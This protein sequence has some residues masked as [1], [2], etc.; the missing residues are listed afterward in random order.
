MICGRTESGCVIRS[1]IFCTLPDRKVRGDISESNYLQLLI[2]LRG[3]PSQL[4]LFIG[5]LMVFNGYYCPGSHPPFGSLR[6]QKGN[7]EAGLLF[8]RTCSMRPIELHHAHAINCTRATWPCPRPARLSRRLVVEMT[9]P[10]VK[11]HVHCQTCR[12]ACCFCQMYY[13]TDGM[14]Y[15][16]FDGI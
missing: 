4:I 10:P 11:L 9:R 5:F 1:Q 16:A 15:F 14:T 8:H 12:L 6:S 2:I 3:L 13:C 7:V